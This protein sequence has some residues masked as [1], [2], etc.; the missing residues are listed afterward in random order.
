MKGKE[1]KIGD[2][3][4]VNW[5]ADMAI[6]VDSLGHDYPF[7]KLQWFRASD[8]YT[9]RNVFPVEELKVVSESR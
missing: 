1:I 6:V 9:Y 8:G 5:G 2:L 7:V 4:K 3:V